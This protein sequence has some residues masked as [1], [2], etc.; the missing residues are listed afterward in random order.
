MSQTVVT[1]PDKLTRLRLW[2]LRLAGVS[3]LL[4]LLILIPVV[5]HA[6]SPSSIQ[7]IWLAPFVYVLAGT[8]A[9]STVLGVWW[10]YTRYPEH[11][12]TITI[13]L[14]IVLVVMAAHLYTINTPT[15]ANCY[16]SGTGVQ[17]C[18]MDEVY[19]VPAAQ[20]LLS[21]EKCGPYLDNCNL[22]HPFLAKAF[23]A[24][25]IKLFGNNTFGWRFF[26][27]L[28]GTASIPVLFGIC[29]KLTK[30]RELSLIATFLLAF[31]TY[32]F[33]QSSIAVI[34]VQMIFF[35]L[36]ALL[37]YLLDIH[38]WKLNR[39]V[40]TGLLCGLSLLSKEIGVFL[41][42]FVI[43]YNLLYGSGS[44][45]RRALTSILMSAI[46]VVL[47]IGGLQI[48]DSLFGN[49][50][51]STF[52]QDISYILHYGAGLKGN[53]WSLFG[54]SGPPYIT[55]FDWFL[56]YYPIG[57]DV[58]RVSVTS[59]SSV[60]Q[61]VSV[62]YFGV[63]NFFEVWF[64]YLWAPFVAFL[65]YKGWRRSRT[66][67][68]P[69]SP[70][71]ANAEPIPDVQ[72]TLEGTALVS[73]EKQESAD[74][75]LGRMAFLWLLFTYVPYILLFFYGRVTYPY[76]ILSADPALAIGT[77]YVMTRKWFPR[78]V[79]YIFL[80]GTAA[81]FFIFYPDKSFLPIWLRAFLGH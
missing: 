4:L 79:A 54:G 47:F 52:I 32:F 66:A 73:E 6:A 25:G 49:P 59:G 17:G 18:V 26:E 48:Y 20:A 65:M 77:A 76:Y 12:K 70:E 60:T 1:P 75:G 15:T 7:A 69:P 21:G 19:Y 9:A 61:Y 31:D 39:Y 41:V 16:D 8:S 78:E 23:I 27:G 44:I 68:T 42:A 46:A 13:V 51:A 28:L 63:P 5:I 10:V 24:A 50:Q 45:Q 29:W 62:G 67:I 30:N 11:K 58:V 53:G 33:V 37:V 57:Y 55:P 2:W 14:A 43:F 64:T 71:P 34:D 81:W 22:E 3:I 36:L 56:Y 74:F 80:G 38:F 40:I 35:G 72:L